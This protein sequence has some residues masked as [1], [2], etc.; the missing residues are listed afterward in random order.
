[1]IHHPERPPLPTPSNPSIAWGGLQGASTGLAL[2]RAI[3]QNN[4]P[5]LIIT[6]DTLTANQLTEELAFF[7]NQKNPSPLLFFPDWETL[8]YDIFSPHKDIIS[9]RLATLYRIPSLKKGAII[10]PISTLMCRLA[11]RDFLDGTVFLLKKGDILRLDT[12]RGRLQKAGYHCVEYV[13][14]HGEFS[15]R[16][17]I[18]D[19]F[20]MG[21]NTPYRLD[22]LDDEIDSIRTFSP[23]TQRSI[24]AIN[25]IAL[26]PAK[27]F[28]LDARAIILFQQQ[29]KTHFDSNPEYS[30][31]YQE[32]LQGIA[33]PGIEYYLPLFFEKTATLLDY[34]PDHSLVI[35]VDAVHTTAE[36]FW[37]EISTRHAQRA[38]NITRPLLAPKELFIPVPLLFSQMQEHLQ[39]SVQ[40]ESLKTHSHH[41]NFNTE[42]PISLK[43]DH[44]ATKPLHALQTFIA[45]NTS[46]IL[47]CAET[48]GR[49]EVLLPLL[50]TVGIHPASVSSWHDFLSNNA[51]HSITV[52]PLNAGLRLVDPP[53]SLITEAELLG[54]RVL[55]RRRRQVVAPDQDAL[56]KDITELNIGSPIVHLEQGIGRYLGLQ[57]LDVGGQLAEF[58]TLEYANQAKLYVPVASLHLISRYN[59]ADTDHAPLHTLGTEQWQR[60]KKKAAKEIEDI[61]ADLLDIYAKREARIGFTYQQKTEDYAAFAASFPFEET[62]DQQKAIDHVI[63]DMTSQKPMDRLV[64]GDVGFGKTEVAMRAAFLAAQNGKQVA[65]LVPTTLLAQ[66]HYESFQNRFADWPIHIGSLSRFQSKQNL[67]ETLGKLASGKMDIVI[68]THKILQP[69]VVFKDLGLVIIDEEHRFGVKQKE[70][71]KALRSDV[72]ILT[73][74]ATPI[75]RTLNMAFAS[76]RDLSLITT[77]PARRLAIKTFVETKG[78]SLLQ[79]AI[80]RELLRGG[81]VYFIHNDVATIERTVAELSQLVPFARIGF[82]HGQMAETAL[83]QIMSDFY[84]RR[85]NVLVCTTIVESGIDVPSANTIIMD[86]AD[87]L[88][89]AQLHQLR[90]RVGR[91][92]HQAYA[93]LLTPPRESLS[94][95]A[96]KRLDAIASLEEL[97][98]GFTLATHD[99]EI[100]GAGELLGKNQSGQMHA[101]GLTLYM[102]LL[103]QAVAALKAGQSVEQYKQAS[104]EIDITLNIPALIP[105]AYLGDVN[106]RLQYYKKIAMANTQRELDDIHIELIDRFGLLPLPAKNLIAIRMMKQTAQHIGIIKIDANDCGGKIEFN[107]KPNI[108]PRHI[109]HLI[110]NRSTVFRLETPNRLRFTLPKHEPDARIDHVKRVLDEIMAK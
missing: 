51:P 16:G 35:T 22:L 17:A 43:A 108:D 26:L 71:L 44:A 29:W 110:Q 87:K 52:A 97:G 33:S 104:P 90:G 94:S 5:V 99:L 9:E 34:L 82:A 89:L 2:A 23:D 78:D 58:L 88:G 53:L 77:P 31:L 41:F 109:I 21:S 79:E 61:A 11:P 49:R 91:S 100:R 76:I 86:R 84:H 62:P 7:Q 63:H 103:S 64:C 10:A 101:I 12:I 102:D 56:V 15:V 60:A 1:M 95:D 96:V 6:P 13:R 70:K 19:L 47:F 48:A 67:A 98:A 54:E 59:G 73:L 107:A 92:H 69:D 68:G 105:E 37:Q 30:A 65:L 80:S 8:P 74:T 45:H 4:G 66:Q 85:F 32:I 81:Q 75:P 36:R 3:E 57:T 18:L 14:E 40:K 93:Y 50:K 83:E 39:I 20:P 38:S 72:D 55:Q 42:Q 46:R 28:P 24:D 27:E 106:I 25:E